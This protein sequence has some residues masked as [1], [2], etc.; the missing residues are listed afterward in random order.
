MLSIAGSIDLTRAAT[1][2]ITLYGGN[3]WPAHQLIF[4]DDNGPIDFSAATAMEMQ[5]KTAAKNSVYIQRLTLGSGLSVSGTSHNII[6]IQGTTLPVGIYVYDLK[7]TFASGDKVTYLKGTITVI[8][9][10]TP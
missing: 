2:D 3:T 1:L 10:V 9:P 7:V 8:Q 4:A 5:I 6:T